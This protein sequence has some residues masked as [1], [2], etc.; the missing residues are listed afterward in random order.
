M[1]GEKLSN[2]FENQ[3]GGGGGGEAEATT[4][5]RFTPRRRRVLRRRGDSSPGGASKTG[6]TTGTDSGNTWPGKRDREQEEE[7]VRQEEAPTSTARQT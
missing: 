1:D 4:S 5:C 3:G 2:P 6:K 7:G